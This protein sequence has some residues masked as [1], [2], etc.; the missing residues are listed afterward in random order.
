LIDLHC[1]VLPALD[2]GPEDLAESVD[3]AVQL[4][5]DGVSTVAATPHLREDHPAVVPSELAERCEALNVRLAEAH[6]PLKVVPGAE[7]DLV[8]A[9]EATHDELVLSSYCQRG[10][11]LLI[12][13]PYGV[14]PGS[15]EEFVF[16]LQVKGFRILLAHPERNP[17][18][19][20][21][22][23]RLAVL[24]DRGVLVQLTADSLVRSPRE[25]RSARAAREFLKKD[26][27]HVI[28]SDGH[29]SVRLTRATLSQGVAAARDVV[30][31]RADWMVTDA[32]AAILAGEP[33]P[34]PPPAAPK[35]R[36]LFKR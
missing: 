14:L 9:G 11:D 20:E 32:P 33:L 31:S 12:E 19:Q 4:V 21:D 24:V 28:A 6:V 16:N 22:A 35:R 27:A 18:F 8:R 3:L 34:E 5:D 23:D 15:F 7:I 13:T 10:A 36:R 25:S 1:H 29:S 26:L 17:T 30:G 2:D